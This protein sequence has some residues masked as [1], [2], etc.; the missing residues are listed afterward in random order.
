M[1]E[2]CKKIPKNKKTKILTKNKKRYTINNGIYI[3]NEKGKR[4]MKIKKIALNILIILVIIISII[5]KSIYS[6]SVKEEEKTLYLE[7]FRYANRTN[8]RWLCIKDRR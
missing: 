5:F 4:I 2:F 8:S 1:V 6:Y 7:Y 3:T